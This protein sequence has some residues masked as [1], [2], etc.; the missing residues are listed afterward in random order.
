[1]YAII[2]ANKISSNADAA[3]LLGH[4][5]RDEKGGHTPH[6]ADQTKAD[7][8]TLIGQDSHKEAYQAYLDKLPQKVRKNGVR[9]I[10]YLVAASPEAMDGKNRDEQD[11]YMNDAIDWLKKKHGAENVVGAAIH[12]DEKTPHLHVFV[13][14]YS[15]EKDDQGNLKKPGKLN[16]REFLGG[17]AKL[18]QMQ[19]AFAN[20]VGKKHNLNRG[21][22]GS[23]ATHETVKEYY[24]R[25]RTKAK[26]P[27]VGADVYEPQ[28]LVKR[29][30]LGDIYEGGEEIK[31]RVD[32]QF[33]KE[34]SSLISKNNEALAKVKKANS[35]LAK[36]E[37]SLARFKGLE[38][39]AKLPKEDKDHLVELADNKLRELKEAAERAAS[40]ERVKA[41][42]DKARED[43]KPKSNEAP[44]DK[45]MER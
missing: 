12:R 24:A 30:L 8:N 10:E 37:K 42:M 26:M 4:S 32:K 20:E 40:A 18:V 43:K 27:S 23:R 13:V 9:M 31:E 6:N 28:V 15:Q 19:T 33:K 44:K 25:I 21:Q 2:R 35:A 16:C 38:S 5:F 11:A 29:R 34:A 14:P 22:E 45:G 39:I 17:K 7:Q 36:S 1:M 3:S 41:M